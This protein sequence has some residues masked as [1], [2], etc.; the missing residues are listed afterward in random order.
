MSSSH[1]S[2][3]SARGYC[4]CPI[5]TSRARNSLRPVQ[6]KLLWWD[7]QHSACLTLLIC[8]SFMALLCADSSLDDLASIPFPQI[9]THSHT[10]GVPNLPGSKSQSILSLFFSALYEVWAICHHILN[11]AAISA[12]VLQCLR[13]EGSWLDTDTRCS[14]SPHH[15][16]ETKPLRSGQPSNNN[17]RH[18]C[19]KNGGIELGAAAAYGADH[20]RSRGFGSPY[21]WLIDHS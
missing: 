10:W 8:W 16:A 7:I 2:S 4:N 13:W 15:T 11:V 21:W 3:P 6:A 14:S 1:P 12:C 20:V 9:N 18:I 19:V 17:R 5:K